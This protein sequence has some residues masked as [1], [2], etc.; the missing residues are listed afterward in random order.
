MEILE[1]ER[2]KLVKQ[3][4]DKNEDFEDYLNKE[5]DFEDFETNWFEN[6]SINIS[7]CS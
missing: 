4:L 1:F 5:K 2:Q 3:Y 6:K 7:H